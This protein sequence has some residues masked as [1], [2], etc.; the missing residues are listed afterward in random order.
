[1]DL[2]FGDPADAGEATVLYHFYAA[3]QKQKFGAPD[4]KQSFSAPGHIVN[5]FDHTVPADSRRCLDRRRRH[6]A[7]GD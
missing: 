6:H 4:R 3:G 5:S 2:R 7:R 1:L